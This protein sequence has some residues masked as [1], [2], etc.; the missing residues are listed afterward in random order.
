MRK[1]LIILFVIVS[2]MACS[3]DFGVFDSLL[4]HSN[5]YEMSRRDAS[6]KAL[7]YVRKNENRMLFMAS[8]S[9]N[10]ID[11]KYG[12]SRKLDYKGNLVLQVPVIRGLLTSS[13]I[14]K[15]IEG[16]ALRPS[17]LF[18]F[19]KEG[20]ITSV[21]YVEQMPDKD[22]YQYHSNELFYSNFIG[23]LDA[24][25]QNDEYQKTTRVSSARTRSMTDSTYTLPDVVITAPD[26]NK[27]DDDDD[28]PFP[29]ETDS[30]EWD[31]GA[32]EDTTI[33]E[34]KFCNFC[35]STLEYDETEDNY[36]CPVCGQGVNCG[37]GGG[38]TIGGNTP[39]SEP[40]G[41]SSVKGI[42]KKCEFGEEGQAKL[43]I[44]IDEQ[45]HKNV[46]M[47]KVYQWLLNNDFGFEQIVVSSVL[48]NQGRYDPT[49][50][51]YIVRSYDDI[52]GSI[53][54]EYLHMFQDF[55]YENGISQYAR[56]AGSANIEFEV[57]LLQ[58]IACNK[59]DNI[60]CP[61]MGYGKLYEQ[62]YNNWVLKLAYKE[63]SI[64]FS[65]I[66]NGYDGVTYEQFLEDFANRN[67]GVVGYSSKY[68]KRGLE[69]AA[70]KLLFS[71]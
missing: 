32:A 50:K 52:S 49:T 7:N 62:K 1:L 31:E 59:Y 46:L 67:K 35:G 41:E 53:R 21:T 2:F 29:S 24:Y 30:I 40:K 71:K 61:C 70:I 64:V 17:V 15:N 48:A 4:E 13:I 63:E 28:N 55:V 58:D 3:D 43:K 39:A 10:S 57:K 12:L 69:P 42:Y 23:E 20:N 18:S 60:G 34:D 11:L 66:I 37:G 33:V 44:A 26:K 47:E 27:D 51:T 65:D 56:E 45:I 36:Y 54:E 6:R 5:T 9:Y 8:H 19:D 22:Y 68:L 38:G 14:E 16:E 25:N